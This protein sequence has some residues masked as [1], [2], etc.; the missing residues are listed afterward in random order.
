[1]DYI[2]LFK[3]SAC[4]WPRRVAL[5]DKNGNRGT[6]YGE[7]D[8]LSGLVAG[9]LH[10]LGFEKGDFIMI[11]MGRQMEYM[12]AYLGILK[13]GCVVVPVVPDYPEDRIDFIRKDC[14]SR[15]TVTA[16]FFDDI[17]NFEP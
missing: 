13:A 17:E 14:G 12:A 3:S 9:K 1:M 11:N 4:R 8:S 10:S 15:L 5:V 2:S 7:L 16:A 6:T